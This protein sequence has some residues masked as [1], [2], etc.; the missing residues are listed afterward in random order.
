MVP[1]TCLPPADY[2]GQMHRWGISARVVEIEYEIL[3]PGR[4]VDAHGP[5]TG[6]PIRINGGDVRPFPFGGGLHR[7][8]KESTIPIGVLIST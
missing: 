2:S 5:V 7:L 3:S 1:F 4:E 8:E 6:I